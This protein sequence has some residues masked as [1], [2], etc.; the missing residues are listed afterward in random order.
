MV[1]AIAIDHVMQ[2]EWK[3]SMTPTVCCRVSRLVAT[4]VLNKVCDLYEAKTLH[5]NITYCENIFQGCI[6]S[7]S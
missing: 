5:V 4:H 7:N 2:T 6:G 3:L 1:I